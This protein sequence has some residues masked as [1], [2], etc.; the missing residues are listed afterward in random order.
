[1]KCTNYPNNSGA[2]AFIVSNY[3]E[4]FKFFRKNYTAHKMFT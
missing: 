3:L 2:F 1:M 4:H